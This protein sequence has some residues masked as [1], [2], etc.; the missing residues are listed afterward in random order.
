MK[1]RGHD[2]KFIEKRMELAA[3]QRSKIN[4]FDYV[5]DNKDINTTISNI[6]N[7]I[8]NLEVSWLNH[9]LKNY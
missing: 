2:N 7:I 4:D 5:V 3:A 8:Y 9:Q 1:D 6:L